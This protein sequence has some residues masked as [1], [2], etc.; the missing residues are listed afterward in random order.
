MYNTPMALQKIRRIFGLLLALVSLVVLVWGLRSGRVLSQS[1]ALDSSDMSLPASPG[2][3]DSAAAAL[4]PAP[5]LLELS[6]PGSLR[7]GDQGELRLSVTLPPGDAMDDPSTIYNDYDLVLQSHLDLPGITRTPTG[8][9]SPAMEPSHPTTVLWY[10]RPDAAGDFTGKVWLHLRFIPR[11]G[12]GQE[13]RIILA[14]QQV[15][16]GVI[17]LFGLSGSQARLFGSLGLAIG[18]VLCL[19]GLVARLLTRRPHRP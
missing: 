14:A 3:G 11:S 4:A 1:T 2:T 13:Q 10:L 16:I 5:R 19:D 18:A 17:T 7:L 15:D 6:W 12:G 8:E 9:V